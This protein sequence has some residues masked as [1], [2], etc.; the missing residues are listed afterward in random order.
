[1]V[2]HGAAV[3]HYGLMNYTMTFSGSKN[4]TEALKFNLQVYSN[5]VLKQNQ[6]FSWNYWAG[7]WSYG[8]SNG[9]WEA[10]HPIPEPLTLLVVGSAVAG[11]G[12]YI[13]K[14]RLAL[15]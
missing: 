12:A 1:M 7:G 9:T 4:E 8:A 5:G 14:R 10:Q 2:M 6:D 11:I 13:R 3:N 15:A